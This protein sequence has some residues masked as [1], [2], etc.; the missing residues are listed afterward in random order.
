MEFCPRCGMRLIFISTEDSSESLICPNCN[1]KSKSKSTLQLLTKN[2]PSAE[3]VVVVGEEDAK[4]RTLPTVKSVCSRCGNNEA[5][6]WMYQTRGGD[7]PTTRFFR[8]TRCGMTW[9]EYS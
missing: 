8:C 4:I 1:Y 5:F 3:S 6:W 7:E 2:K 9:R